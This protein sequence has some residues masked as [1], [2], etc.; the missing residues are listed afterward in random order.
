MKDLMDVINHQ[1]FVCKQ[2]TVNKCNAMEKQIKK[3]LAIPD[4]CGTVYDKYDTFQECI[5]ALDS[6][7]VGNGQ[8]L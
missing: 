5:R 4:I 6:K 1:L 3:E 8:Q 7:L 2:D